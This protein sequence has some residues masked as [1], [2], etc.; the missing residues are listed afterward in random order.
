MKTN[1]T[2][3]QNTQVLFLTMWLWKAMFPSPV[4]IDGPFNTV[5]FWWAAWDPKSCRDLLKVTSLAVGGKGSFT[6]DHLFSKPLLFPLQ[7][8]GHQRIINSIFTDNT[9]LSPSLLSCVLESACWGGIDHMILVCVGK[10]RKSITSK[11]ENFV[12]CFLFLFN[13]RSVFCS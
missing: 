5:S 9:N 8:Q 3:S 11:G 12:D 13:F 2:R 10:E 4:V 6:S 1:W 7:K